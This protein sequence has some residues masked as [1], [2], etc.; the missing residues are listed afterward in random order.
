MIDNQGNL[1]GT[2]GGG[3]GEGDGTVFELSP[4]TVQGGTWT[5]KILWAFGGNLEADGCDPLDKLLF[6]AAGNLYGTTAACG[7][8]KDARGIAFELSPSSDETWAETLLHTFRGTNTDS[9]YGYNPTA[10]LAFDSSGNL[11]GTTFLGGRLLNGV[12]YELSPKSG[13]GWQ[14]TVVHS[15]GSNGPGEPWSSVAIDQAGALYGTLSNAGSNGT[16][17]VG[18]GCGG[19]FRTKKKSGTWVT[20]ILP[21]D[22][23]N[24]GNP[25][26]GIFL[27]SGKGFGT[28]EYGGAHG[29]GTIF[30]A[31]PS[32]VTVL[33]D[34]CSEASCADGSQPVATLTYDGAGHYYGV[35]TLG[36]GFNQGVVFEITP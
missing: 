4:P 21:F 11:Y 12:V 17:C 8:G 34:F 18:H 32:G 5:E 27:A 23:T 10:G 33:Y 19:I 13:G 2:S 6:D 35:T 22:G 24:G 36:G 15:F 26:A 1:Y 25:K 7:A 14:Y 16:G 3:D 9:P 20:S 29:Q 28:T 30:A 31:Q